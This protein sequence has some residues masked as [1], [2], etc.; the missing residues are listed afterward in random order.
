MNDTDC[1]RT[2][3]RHEDERDMARPESVVYASVTQRQQAR[4]E[5]EDMSAVGESRF[6][7]EVARRQNVLFGDIANITPFIGRRRQRAYAR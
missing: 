7:A 3:R 5:A 4:G 2:S 6:E 1:R